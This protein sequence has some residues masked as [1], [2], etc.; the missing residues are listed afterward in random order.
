MTLL[1]QHVL[2]RPLLKSDVDQVLKLESKTLHSADRV[3]REL[4]LY[5]LKAAPELSSGIFVRTQR[6]GRWATKQHRLRRD[7][8]DSNTSSCSSSSS[9]SSATSI[10][11]SSPPSGSG[12][13]LAYRLFGGNS[14]KFQPVEDENDNNVNA[15]PRSRE[16]L[17]GFL[18]AVKT[19]NPFVSDDALV[20]TTS[21]DDLRGH[22]ETGSTIAIVSFCVDPD[23]QGKKLG[24]TLIRDFVQRMS[25]QSVASRIALL[26]RDDM[27]PF[28]E[29]LGFYDAGKSS[30]HLGTGDWN[31]LYLDLE[32]N[33]DD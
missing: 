15:C 25:T 22:V 1:P 4:L 10:V 13:S 8:T 17:I 20:A 29:R 3:S 33:D 26:G 18:I 31:D 14:P 11:G 7:S 19:P 28:F 9:S 16:K 2:I 30:A 24:T 32:D 27:I 21:G 6:K 23:F 12:S 5:R